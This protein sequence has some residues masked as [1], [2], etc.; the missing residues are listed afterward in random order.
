MAKEWDIEG[1][2]PLRPDE[3][4]SISIKRVSWVCFRCGHKWKA[5]IRDRVLKG[6]GCAK[7]ACKQISKRRIRTLIGQRGSLAESGLQI[8]VDWNYDRNTISPDEITSHSNKKVWWKCHV[9]GYEWEATIS[10]RANGRGCPCCSHKKLVPGKNDL[11]TTHPQLASE[12]H[13][14]K[15]GDLTP[16]DVMFGQARKVWWFCPEGHSYRRRLAWY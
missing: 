6:N 2:A 3:V 7:C 15:N 10:N 4:T 9:C 8:L 11:A 1:N 5:R 13:P 12:W 14:G 16:Q